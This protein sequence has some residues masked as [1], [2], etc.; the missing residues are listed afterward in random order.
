MKS[1][2]IPIMSSRA[3]KA[4]LI[5]TILRRPM[6]K[7]VITSIKEA[8]ATGSTIMYGTG[9]RKQ[10]K[11]RVLGIPVKRERDIILT[12]ASSESSPKIMETI[13]E[14][15]EL[16]RPK[17]GICFSIDT[18]KVI[19]THYTKLEKRNEGVDTMSDETRKYDLIVTIVNKGEAETVIDASRSAGADGG[20]IISGRGTGVHETAKILNILIEPEKEIVLT[21]VPRK[22]TEKVLQA[23][24]EDERLDEPGKGIAFVM[25]VDEVLG[26]NH[27]V[28]NKIRPELEKLNGE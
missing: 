27:V 8:G 18:K 11:S 16:N 23:I 5:V 4:K 22:I 13:Y 10:E 20:T 15:A 6:T 2:N 24:N 25:E 12:V 21:L 26:I 19:G 28:N 3:A 7:K 9:I 14:T 17:T 1:K